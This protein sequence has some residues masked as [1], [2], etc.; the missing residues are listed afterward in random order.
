MRRSLLLTVLFVSLPG[1]SYAQNYIQPKDYSGAGV[2]VNLDVISNSQA[3]LRLAP[4]MPSQ[5]VMLRPPMPM[6]PRLTPPAPMAAPQL[7]APRPMAQPPIAP[8]PMPA[9]AAPAMQ[10]RAMTTPMASAPVPLPVAP[11]PVAPAA[12][13]AMVGNAPMPLSSISAPR[14]NDQISAPQ[15]APQVNAHVAPGP[16][17]L[18]SY[19]IDEPANKTVTVKSAPSVTSE[20][21]GLPPAMPPALAPV[22][23]PVAPKPVQKM[24]PLKD[25]SSLSDAAPVQA[26]PKPAPLKDYSSRELLASAKEK[27]D[28]VD[29]IIPAPAASSLKAMKAPSTTPVLDELLPLDGTGTLSSPIA[30]LP[31]APEEIV[32]VKPKAQQKAAP[33]VAS[34]KDDFKG[35]RIV[36]DAKSEK[37]KPSEEAMLNKIAAQMTENKSLRLQVRA[38]ADGTPETTSAARRLSLMRA[39]NVRDYV[40]KKNIPATRLDIRAL[41]SGS[42]EM[43]DE[44]GR[45]SA[46]ADRVDI[47]VISNPAGV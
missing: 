12:T 33:K 29:M 21:L 46:P 1:F 8:A 32:A 25:Y 17:S 3:P 5:R 7:V 26:A 14:N 30:A 23:A 2:I 42:A 34:I 44:V 45:S 9:P 41:G 37:I 10:P 28:D 15:T 20:P 39:L 18:E 43:G 27:A 31:D 40:T 22:P 38:Y 13:N 24:A 36:F 4:P 35:Y 6:A 47:T 19:L 11:K 16:K